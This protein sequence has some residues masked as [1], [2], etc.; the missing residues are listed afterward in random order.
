[1]MD[2]NSIS[3]EVL[4][5]MTDLLSRHL[6]EQ[7]TKKGRNETERYRERDEK[8]VTEDRPM[9]SRETADSGGRRATGGTL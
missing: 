4:D 9:Q 1:M 6:E 2:F 7:L 3:K 8:A 5:A